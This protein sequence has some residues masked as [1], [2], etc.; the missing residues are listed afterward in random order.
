MDQQ[1]APDPFVDLQ[2][3]A[4]KTERRV[5]RERRSRLMAG[6]VPVVLVGVA[7]LVVL[8]IA[9]PAVRAM[10]P[11]RGG[12]QA[13]AY[14]VG[15][16]ATES[17]PPGVTVT[18]S[19]SAP[20]TDPF[21]GTPAATY[22]KGAAGISLPSTALRGFTTAQINAALQQVRKAL[23]AGRLD[24]RMLTGHDPSV[25]L[26]LITAGERD[27]V[28]REFF[29]GKDMENLATWIAPTAKLD[30]REQ[31]RV[32]GRVTVASFYVG[33][34]RQ[35]RITTNFIWVYAFRDAPDSPLAAVH[36]E[37]EWNFPTA[38]SK[39]MS[40]GDT[41]SYIAW[42]DCSAFDKGMLAPGAAV[43]KPVPSD[44]EDPKAILKADH[45][46]DIGNDCK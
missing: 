23:V 35:L 13:A 42:G 25:F 24:P 3:W 40:V 41:K 8:G 21:A 6:K 4:K 37:I 2:E 38:D 44:T 17:A 22:P 31:P 30:P 32:S 34:Q 33:F 29:N 45:S 14:P 16:Y 5:K 7:A 18:T 19:A 11:A 27:D 10:L 9:V 43:V 46:L 12:S 20:P 36:D 26:K 28:R 1:D 39:S 15:T